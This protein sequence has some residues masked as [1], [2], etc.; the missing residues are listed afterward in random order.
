[1]TSWAGWEHTYFHVEI[2]GKNNPHL[3]TSTSNDS[4]IEIVWGS[5]PSFRWYL[6]CPE[7]LFDIR[8]DSELA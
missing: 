2:A 8:Q 1:M 5:G 3:T 7:M 4:D 6:T